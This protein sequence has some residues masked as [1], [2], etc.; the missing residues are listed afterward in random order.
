MSNFDFANVSLAVSDDSKYC[1][2][3]DIDNIM[4][5][6]NSIENSEKEKNKEI[7]FYKDELQ[8]QIVIN[9]GLKKKISLLETDEQKN[10]IKEL[11]EIN[12]ALR[13]RVVELESGL[14][15][16]NINVKEEVVK[17]IPAPIEQP[18]PKAATPINTV[19]SV[20]NRDNNERKR[21]GLYPS[22]VF[23]GEKM[24]EERCSYSINC[25]NFYCRYSHPIGRVLLCL[26]DEKC[27]NGCR[28]THKTAKCQRNLSCRKS[29]CRLQHSKGRPTICTAV[30]CKRNCGLIHMKDNTIVC[31]YDGSCRYAGCKFIHNKQQPMPRV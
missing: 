12:A 22:E 28:L 7:K 21:T 2:D 30:D 3:I 15:M 8:K 27:V 10:Q 14:V 5:E 23:V 31:R 11:I 6:I 16:L 24:N 9:S 13:K 17:A 26:G 4:K 25:I 19:N 1:T 20:N 18:A 29:D